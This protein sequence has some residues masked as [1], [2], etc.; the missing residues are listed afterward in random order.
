MYFSFTEPLE[1]CRY[2]DTSCL[3]TSHKSLRRSLSCL[4]KLIVILYHFNIQLTFK[5]PQLPQ[6]HIFLAVLFGSKF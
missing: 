2:L 1:N 3:N 5:I 4:R 6:K